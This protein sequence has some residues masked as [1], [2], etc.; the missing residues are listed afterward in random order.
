MPLIRLVKEI[1]KKIG[2]GFGF[3]TGM[4]ISFKI[5]PINRESK[6]LPFSPK[7]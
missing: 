2:Y 3:G 7:F 4:G 1:G 5:L 6:S